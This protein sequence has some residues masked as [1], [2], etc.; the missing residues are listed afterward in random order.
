MYWRTHTYVYINIY[1]CLFMYHCII[2]L[3]YLVLAIGKDKMQF[4]A[5][6]LIWSSVYIKLDEI[7]ES[8]DYLGKKD[9]QSWI[10]KDYKPSF[11]GASS[12]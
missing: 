12:N 9:G 11:A 1:V 2:C 5:G 3:K 8:P 10:S 7:C 6:P 4:I